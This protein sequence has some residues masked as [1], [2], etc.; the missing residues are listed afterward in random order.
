MSGWRAQTRAELK[1]TL[2]RGD[3]VLLTLGIPVG[4]L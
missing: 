3:S 1:M 2:R 4:L